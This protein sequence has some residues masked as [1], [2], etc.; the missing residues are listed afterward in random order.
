MG[1]RRQRR[2]AVA[3]QYAFKTIVNLDEIKSNLVVITIISLV[4]DNSEADVRE[5]AGT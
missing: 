3:Q 2:R 5:Y 4:Y 1:E